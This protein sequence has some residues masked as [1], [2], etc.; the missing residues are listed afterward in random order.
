[1]E[2][3]IGLVPRSDE[4]SKRK[5]R[6][7]S[8]SQPKLMLEKPFPSL[9][10]HPRH[11]SQ[12]S[13]CPM[14]QLDPSRGHHCRFRRPRKPL[15]RASRNCCPESAPAS[16]GS[17][18]SFFFFRRIFFCPEKKIGSGEIRKMDPHSPLI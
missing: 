9:T 6:N 18:L 14:S 15:F 11:N 13:A 4:N 7:F 3:L 1:M 10:P 17:D 5:T 8:A 12:F 2:L 16:V